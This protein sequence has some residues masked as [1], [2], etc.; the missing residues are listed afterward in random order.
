MTYEHIFNELDITV[1][2]FALC[3]LRGEC[4]LGLGYEPRAT[5]HYVLSGRGEILVRG[6][7]PV[8][9]AR[10]SI[11]LIPALQNHSLRSFGDDFDP[12]PTCRPAELDLARLLKTSENAPNG[13]LAAL[14]TNVTIGLRG[15]KDVVDLVREPMVE[16]VSRGSRMEQPL[17]RLIEE[18]SQPRLGSR[19]MVRA[20]LLEC[21]IDML[22]SRLTA[23]DQALAW[24]AALKDPSVW[25][26]LRVML[27]DPGKSHSVDS[28]AHVVGMSRSAFAKRFSEAYGSG[29]MELLRDLR[30]RMAGT[31]LKETELP[32]KRV[33]D[34]VGFSSRSAFSRMFEAK[35]GQS[36]RSFRSSSRLAE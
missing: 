21:V 25:Q 5:L 3:E 18:V 14:C 27:D 4:N 12:L 11:V 7:K 24:M 8:Q 9:V 22:R 30:M 16:C 1:D 19:A 6:R 35:T 31:L 23:Q 26:A 13:Q 2:P 32:V 20:I 15:V 28:L 36:P 17:M 34:M 29:P 10:G 33:A